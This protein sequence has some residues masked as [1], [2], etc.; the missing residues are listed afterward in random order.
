M[1]RIIVKG[2]DGKKKMVTVPR[3]NTGYFIDANN[4]YNDLYNL[5]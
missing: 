2:K 1:Q 3:W 4:T 5:K